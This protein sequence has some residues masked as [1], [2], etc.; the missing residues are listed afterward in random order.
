MPAE[1]KGQNQV[2]NLGAIIGGIKPETA[3]V[4]NRALSGE[5]ITSEEAVCCSAPKARNTTPW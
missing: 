3:A 1:S 2:E 5:D 4:L